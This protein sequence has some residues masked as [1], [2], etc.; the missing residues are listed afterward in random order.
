MRKSDK[1]IIREALRIASDYWRRNAFAAAQANK[2]ALVD[3]DGP[4]ALQ[5]FYTKEAKRADKLAHRWSKLSDHAHY[6]ESEEAPRPL[7]LERAAAI[8]RREL[9][10]PLGVTVPPVRLEW[11]P[12]DIFLPDE[13]AGTD[14]A[15]PDGAPSV[16]HMRD[17]PSNR[18]HLRA[19]ATLAHEMAH[20]AAQPRFNVF[21]RYQFNGHPYHWQALAHAIGLELVKPWYTVPG[22]RFIQFYNEHLRGEA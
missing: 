17:V 8:M 18:D 11:T 3:H 9:F 20:A 19:A 2:A 14:Y 12:P 7:N 4:A 10:G 15:G 13:E 16:I 1:T 5:S 6:L 21:D 22:P